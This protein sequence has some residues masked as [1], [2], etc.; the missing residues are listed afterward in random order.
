M[1]LRHYRHETD[2][3]HH[4]SKESSLPIFLPPSFSHIFLPT[5]CSCL[6]QHLFRC[7][8]RLPFRAAVDYSARNETGR[9][10][11]PVG[12]GEAETDERMEQ[13]GK[14]KVTSSMSTLVAS[15]CFKESDGVIIDI[16]SADL[17]GRAFSTIPLVRP[18]SKLQRRRGKELCSHQA[19]HRLIA[20]SPD[21]VI[22]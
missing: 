2:S 4:C 20:H 8:V 13:S 17:S 16:R 10:V 9:L 19:Q 3:S 22:C 14:E 15:L 7:V 21:S 18:N 11:D 1:F 12:R 5:I 6:R